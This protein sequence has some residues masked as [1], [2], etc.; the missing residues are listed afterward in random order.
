MALESISPATG[1]KLNTFEE[2]SEES[3]EKILRSAHDAFAMWRALSF[4]ERGTCFERLAEQLRERQESLATLISLEMGKPI[5]DARAEIEKSAGACEFF[6]R[7]ASNLLRDVPIATEATKSYV[8]YEPLGVILGI[9]PWNFPVWQVMRYAAPIMMAGNT[10]VLKHANNVSGCALAIE[11]LFANAGFP[12][13]AFRSL[14]IDIPAVD[15]VIRHP[16]IAGVTLTGSPRAGRAVGGAAGAVLKKCVLELGGSDPFI[17]LADANLDDA[18]E[19]GVTSRLLVSGQVCISPKRFIVPESLKSEFESKLVARMGKAQ[20]G[21]PMSDSTDFGPLARQDLRDAVAAQVDACV[22]KGATRLLG[23]TV[24]DGPGA[25]Y[26]ATVL[27]DVGPGMPAYDEEVFGPVAAIIT[28][29]DE[30]AALRVANDS[31]YGLGAVVFS[32]D[33]NRAEEIACAIDA[34]CCFVNSAVR[35]D[36][37]L[38]FGGVKQSGYGREL[39]AHGIKEFTNTKTVY[40]A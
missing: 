7:E 5:R 32:G 1:E 14:I 37:R 18:I 3:C 10:T 4:D 2:H 23:G 24:P 17:I 34:G 15:A 13:N 35:S 9:M 21:D 39:G 40:I 36:P 26:P 22:A 28:V 11:E 20:C 38:P 6:A 12:A 30:A 27:T 8:R 19:A 25:F 31:P 29:P 33:A 16:L